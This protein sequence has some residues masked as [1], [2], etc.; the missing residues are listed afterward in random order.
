MAN[1]PSGPSGQTYPCV[2]CALYLVEDQDGPLGVLLRGSDSRGSEQAVSLAVIAPDLDRAAALAAFRAATV[3][4]NVFRGQVL[5]FDV[6]FGP[7]QA[8]SASKNVPRHTIRYLIGR[9][10]LGLY[11]GALI[12]ESVRGRRR[13]RRPDQRC[14]RFLP[15]GTAAQVRPHRGRGRRRRP[16][17]GDCSQHASRDGTGPSARRAEHNDPHPARRPRG[18]PGAVPRNGRTDPGGAA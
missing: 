15:Q 17:R 1:Q 11:R 9:Q 5:S 6:M 13:R 16:R 2:Q 10:L 7:D 8:R 12:L 14:H 18:W 4:H 3:E